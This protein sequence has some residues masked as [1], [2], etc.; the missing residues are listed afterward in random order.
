MTYGAKIIKFWQLHYILTYKEYSQPKVVYKKISYVLLNYFKYVHMHN[1]SI[2]MVYDYANCI[3]VESG[4][5]NQ[6]DLGV[7]GGQRNM[8]KIHPM[9]F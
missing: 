3:D 5:R 6:M 8:T 7:G 1:M 2:K 4:Q 9:T